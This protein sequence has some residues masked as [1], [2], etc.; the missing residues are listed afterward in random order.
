MTHASLKYPRILWTRWCFHTYFIN[1]FLSIFLPLCPSGFMIQFFYPHILDAT[2]VELFR[3]HY[4]CFIRVLTTTDL[5]NIFGRCGA[6]CLLSHGDGRN[7]KPWPGF[8]FAKVVSWGPMCLKDVQRFGTCHHLSGWN[9]TGHGWSNPATTKALFVGLCFS[10][11][12]PQWIP[13]LRPQK[14]QRLTL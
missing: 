7:K 10:V 11:W 2:Q 14:R 1:V 6:V 3:F 4:I 13:I 9:V 12:T 8:C 5:A